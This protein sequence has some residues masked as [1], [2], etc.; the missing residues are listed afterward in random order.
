MQR[1]QIISIMKYGVPKGEKIID[2][3]TDP[4]TGRSKYLVKWCGLPSFK[5][6]WET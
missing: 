6:S 4:F 3:M 1:W 5:N 2:K